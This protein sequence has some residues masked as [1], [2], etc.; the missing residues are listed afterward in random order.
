MS[1][2]LDRGP[3]LSTSG[4]IFHWARAYDLLL[5][6][7]WGRSEQSYRD[8]VVHFAGLTSGEWVLDVGCGTG[9]LALTA[10]GRVGQ[11]GK[12]IGIDASPEMIARARS[13]AARSALEVDFQI[14]A[15]EALPFLE[16]TF[17]VVLSTTMLHCLPEDARRRSIDEMGRVLKP[18]GRLLIVDFGGPV[19]TR[20]SL[21]A[22]LR[23]HR[24]FDVHEVLPA[25][26]AAGLEH[27]GGGTLGFSDLQFV[28]ARK[29]LTAAARGDH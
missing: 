11:T 27:V 17:G 15:A 3:L 28:L 7:F 16:A 5:R 9:T 12:V 6:V 23:H 26:D 18:G 4:K 14:A 8:K 21:F 25:L 2:I 13:K 20:H 22:H 19:E 24:H 29:P 1:E 10:K